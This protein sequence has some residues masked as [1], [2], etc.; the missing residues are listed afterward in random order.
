MQHGS[1]KILDPRLSRIL[2][3][4]VPVEAVLTGFQFTEGPLWDPH[5]SELLFSDIP[6]NR[7]YA[8]KPGGEPSVYREPSRK[9]NGLTW[10][11]RGRLTACEHAGRRVSVTLEDGEAS[12][13]VTHYRGRR[14]NS[15]NDLVFHSGGTLYFSDPPYGLS[16]PMG[17]DAEQEQPVNGLYLLR[18]GDREPVLA[19][20]DFDRPNGLCFSPDEHHLYVADT[21]RYEIRRFAVASGGE[22]SG[23]EVWARFD[24]DEGAG[25]PDGM[26]MSAGGELFTT[27]PGGLWIL[28]PAG[29][30]LGRVLLPE[31]AANCA[32]GD[33]DFQTLYITASTS[34]YRLRTLTPGIP[35]SG[36]L[37]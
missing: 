3:L 36:R 37:F 2:N 10:D 33:A 15:P 11:S 4:D 5:T 34:I 12:D 24:S 25:R 29:E 6:A 19:A 14:L 1:I 27:G 23:G 18:P 16:S 9:S 22:L 35:P 17:E 13:L 21:P 26:K 32:W 28:S 8:W 20:A 31:K 30:K 7:I